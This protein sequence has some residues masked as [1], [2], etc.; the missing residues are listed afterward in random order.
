MK[1]EKE[2][3]PPEGWTPA[4]REIAVLAEGVGA[5]NSGGGS[6]SAAAHR[7]DSAAGLHE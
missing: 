3:A 5:A 4:S 6:G 1:R 7:V 2:G